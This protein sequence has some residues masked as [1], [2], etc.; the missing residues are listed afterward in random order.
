MVEKASDED[1]P[2]LPVRRLPMATGASA[3]YLKAVWYLS[4]GSNTATVGNVADRVGVSHPSASSSI[5]QLLSAGFVTKG[6][7][8]EIHLTEAGEAE[9]I[10]L[11]RRHRIV[12]TFLA[13]VLGFSWHEV[14]DEAEALE[15]VLRDHL[16]DRM[17]ALLGEPERNP[18]GDP[19]PSA[20]GLIPEL[21]DLPLAQL[22]PGTK[23]RIVRVSSRDSDL[24]RYMH[25]EGL[26]IGTVITVEQKEQFG[27]PLW[28]LSSRGRH[29]L[30]SPVVGAISVIPV[31]L[32]NS[33]GSEKEDR[34][35]T[36]AG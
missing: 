19:I 18:R 25:N 28:V 1:L 34:S 9:A 36:L 8:S 31:G 15:W 32:E 6:P 16:V 4:A 13:V 11:V 33:A 21:N 17:A 2:A 10:R 29:A 35:A 23:A 20:S 7:H 3:R 22:S 5:K 12:E 27:G 24:L 30:G 14:H 26:G